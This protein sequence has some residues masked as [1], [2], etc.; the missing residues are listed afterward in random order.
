MPAEVVQTGKEPSLSLLTRSRLFSIAHNALTNA[1]RHARTS[2]VTI[3]LDF[4][5]SGVRM[6]V[7]D[8]G[9]GL[10]ADYAE[11]GRGFQNMRAEAEH[12]GGRLDVE[13]SR[14][15]GGT[16]VTCVLEHDPA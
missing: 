16:T 3:E 7:V 2:K 10:P 5:A 8:D 13:S 12:M 14:S 1:F 6:S 4:Q 9:I 11:R 15:G